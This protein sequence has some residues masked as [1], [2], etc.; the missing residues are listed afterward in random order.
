MRGLILRPLCFVAGIDYKTLITCPKTDQIWAGHL[1][2]SLF[3]SF[4]V[5]FSIALFSTGYVVSEPRLRIAVALVVA[6]TI[7]LFDRALFQSD[8]FR[9]GSSGSILDWIKQQ[10]PLLVRLPISACLAYVLA[11]FLE[12]AVFADTIS[13]KLHADYLAANAPALARIEA[14]EKKIDD[15]ILARSDVLKGLE[16]SLAGVLDTSKGGAMDEDRRGLENRRLAL[17]EQ[18]AKLQEDA[19]AELFGRKIRPDQTGLAG[20]G[21]AYQFAIAQIEALEKQLNAL[22]DRL[23]RQQDSFDSKRPA[24][25]AQVATLRAEVGDLRST[26]NAK[27]VAFRAEVTGSTEFRPPKDDPLA[28]MAAFQ[29]LKDDP[30]R[31]S[32][33]RWFSLLTLLFVGFLEVVPVLAKILFSPMTA[34]GQL[35][36]AQVEYASAEASMDW[37]EARA[38]EA[39]SVINLGIKQKAKAMFEEGRTSGRG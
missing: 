30:E 25:E 26:R 10:G 15:E 4:L 11:T 1:G 20:P 3:I 23:K 2:L 27:L 38:A 6:L 18:I 32:T 28:R 36:R 29:A 9:K 31:G 13:E 34:Y 22:E 35:V 16:D 17:L 8:W 21:P 5:I 12:L 19:N 39:D 37:H 7:F 24:I 14:F 33:I